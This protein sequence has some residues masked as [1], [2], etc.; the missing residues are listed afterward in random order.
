MRP[1][2]CGQTEQVAAPHPNPL[3]IAWKNAMGRGTDLWARSPRRGVF[4]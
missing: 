3:P 2:S 4:T 1:D